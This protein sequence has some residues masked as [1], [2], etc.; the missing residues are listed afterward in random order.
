ML[1]DWEVAAISILQSGSPFSVICSRPFIAGRDGSGRIVA[2]N[3]CDYNADGFN[4]DFPN[5]PVF[6]NSKTGLS[7]SDYLAGAISRASFPVPSLGQQGDLG[8]NTFRGPGYAGTDV[9]L[10]RKLLLTSPWHGE[11]MKLQL[12]AEI[13][14]LFNRVNL[15]PVNG[16]L[17]S[18]QF[19]RSSSSLP[20][21][22]IQFG[23]RLEF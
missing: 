11:D 23:V 19:G 13:F 17:A 12:R 9:T 4:Y 18:Q 2:N 14:N 16:D 21:R 5:T 3:G 6:G 8:R 15:G 22:N 10:I 20:A 1:R 7:R